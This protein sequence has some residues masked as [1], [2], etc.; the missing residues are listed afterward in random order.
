MFDLSLE[1]Q[2]MKKNT[3]NLKDEPI[4]FYKKQ[5][6]AQKR[7]LIKFKKRRYNI[8]NIMY[9]ATGIPFNSLDGEI[10]PTI[11]YCI[12]HDYSDRCVLGAC[13]A[14]LWNN[15]LIDENEITE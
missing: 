2:Y 13:F 10:G 8:L 6:A 14:L 11:N 4:K 9:A 3:N 15:H 5:I 7:A 12:G 1:L